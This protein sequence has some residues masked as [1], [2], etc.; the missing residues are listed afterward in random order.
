MPAGGMHGTVGDCPTHTGG[1]NLQPPRY[2]S[3]I[4]HTSATRDKRVRQIAISRGP[5]AYVAQLVL[6]A[7]AYF[8]SAKLSLLLAIPPG[9]ATAV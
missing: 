8:V 5:F 1:P 6:L 4:E 3:R 9:Y 7:G 2:N